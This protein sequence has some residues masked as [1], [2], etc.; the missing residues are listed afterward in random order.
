MLLDMDLIAKI[1]SPIFV[2][3]I[4]AILK[5]YLEGRPRL[6]VYLVHASAHP[7]PNQN[8]GQ[9][10]GNVHTHSIVVRNAGKKSAHNV[11]VGHA[12]LPAS[13]QIHPPVS[14]TVV[15]G[16]GGSAEIVIPVL[17]PN[18]QISISYLYFPPLVWNQIAAYTKSDEGMAK[19]ID[20]IP[21]PIL[22]KPII[23]L[24]WALIFVG[25]STCTY[26]AFH[27]I[28]NLLRP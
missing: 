6:I 2:A 14:H 8:Q 26:W 25:A 4:G 13:Y 19:Q 11:R 15:S 9:Q 21:S 17:V 20:V 22:S 12:F 3:V 10:S 28:S 7:L 24:L 18:E 1:V 23:T 16:Q 5:K 27:V